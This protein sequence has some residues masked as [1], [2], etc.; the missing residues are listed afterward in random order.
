MCHWLHD[1]TLYIN[2]NQM[3][4][5]KLLFNG[6]FE[7]LPLQLVV[8][9]VQVLDIVEECQKMGRSS[10]SSQKPSQFSPCHLHYKIITK[11]ENM[12]KN[13]GKKGLSHASTC[14]S[15]S[16]PPAVQILPLHSNLAPRKNTG[17]QEIETLYKTAKRSIYK[18]KIKDSV[19]ITSRQNGKQCET[20]FH[21]KKWDN[22]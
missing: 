8:E 12:K 13:Q 6:C 17:M 3:K 7:N 19:K 9:W 1:V 16:R 5:Y 4:L 10:Q 22:F 18:I 20:L 11:L 14:L 15:L 21:L 2:E